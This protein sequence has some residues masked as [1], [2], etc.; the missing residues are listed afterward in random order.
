MPSTANG[1]FQASRLNSF[2]MKLKRPDRVVEREDE[3]DADR[4]QQV[5]Q[6][7][8]R[9]R[10]QQ[11]VEPAAPEGHARSPSVPSSASVPAI[12]AQIRTMTSMNA[13]SRNESAAAVG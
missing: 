9:V 8:P 11:P 12:R 4:E 6:R 10:V 2:Q 1:C 13:I 3:N 5:D 7:E